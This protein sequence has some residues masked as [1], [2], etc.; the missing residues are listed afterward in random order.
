MTGTDMSVVASGGDG[1]YTYAWSIVS[2]PSGNAVIGS[3]TS[4]STGAQ[5]NDIPK[6]TVTFKCTVSDGYGTPPADSNVISVDP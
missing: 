2:D 6:V 5:L 3:P 4:Q 1:N